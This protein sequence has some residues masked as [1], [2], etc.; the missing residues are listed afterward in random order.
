MGIVKNLIDVLLT[1]HNLHH[2]KEITLLELPPRYLSIV[3]FIHREENS[4]YDGIGLNDSY[5]RY[6]IALRIPEWPKGIQV[7]GVTPTELSN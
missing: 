4:M 7:L 3:A 1:V 5:D 2:A 6:R